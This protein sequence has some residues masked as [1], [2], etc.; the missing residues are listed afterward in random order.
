V[1]RSLF[2]IILGLSFASILPLAAQTLD[3][4]HESA[5]YYV[6][7]P[8][9]KVYPYR[10]GYVV[11]YRKGT[12][13]RARTYLPIEW[14]SASAGKGEVIP[15]GTGPGW[16]RLVIYYKDKEFSHVRLYVRRNMNHETW[17]N[18]PLNVNIDDRFED[19]NDIKLEF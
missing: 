9:E 2:L 5:F 7:V 12:A 19:V 6:S 10:K 15:Q 1:K 18:I 17:G 16:P 14:F 4:D 13:G 11:E 3:K 8:I